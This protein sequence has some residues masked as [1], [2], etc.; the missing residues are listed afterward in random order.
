LFAL[1]FDSG[2]KIKMSYHLASLS[3]VIKLR[4][5]GNSYFEKSDYTNP[6]YTPSPYASNIHLTRLMI[7]QINN[8]MK[9]ELSYGARPVQHPPTFMKPRVS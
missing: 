6:I 5:F 3:V 8:S 7:N 2:S 4:C 1:H 9:Q